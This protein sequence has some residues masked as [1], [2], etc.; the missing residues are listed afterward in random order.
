M[1][2]LSAGI[3]ELHAGLTPEDKVRAV[4][5]GCLRTSTLM[6]GD[7]INDA[8]ALAAA[9]VGVAMGASGATASAQA[10]GV[11][12]LVDRLDRLVEALDIARRT[13]YI[14]RQGVLVGMGMSLLAMT[15]AALGY[16]P[17][18]IGAV[19]QEGID[20]VIILN[21]L[22]ALGPLRALRKR[23]LTAEHIDRLQ[24]EHQQLA[25]VLCDLHQLAND[26]AHRP[27]AQAQADLVE[28]V[29]KLQTSL[30]QHEREDEK[31]LYPLLTRNMP[32][33]DP[34]SAMSHAHREIFRL[35]H[36]LARMSSDF[37]SDPATASADEIQ[38][39]LIRLD[40]LVRLHFDQEEELFR[41]L[42]WR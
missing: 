25:T 29:N 34:M 26:F 27:L 32:G 38:H 4:Q 37:S 5:Q 13:R 35:I 30:A 9:N 2:A 41:Y 20:V 23:K 19:V 15:V 36:L 8:P 7:G 12:L 31:M 3:D 22:R 28:L 21:A 11:V 6:V 40:T 17:P 39:Q 14:A 24:D 10:A 33:E 16:L 18:L 1:I 42:D